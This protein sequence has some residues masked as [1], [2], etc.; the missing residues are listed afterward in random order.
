MRHALVVGLGLVGILLV[1]IFLLGFL[2]VGI[3]LG[4]Y[5]FGWSEAHN[6]Q[7]IV[8]RLQILEF[9]LVSGQAGIGAPELFRLLDREFLRLALSNT[10]QEAAN[11]SL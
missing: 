7:D 4:G 9:G 6:D 8:P 5:G 11:A 3:L 10:Y 2:L 1:R